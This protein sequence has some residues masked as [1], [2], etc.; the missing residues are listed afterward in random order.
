MRLTYEYAKACH[1]GQRRKNDENYIVH[2]VEVT[3]LLASIPGIDQATLQAA[4]L[5]DVLEDTEATEID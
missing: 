2:P 3:T 5:H 4:L 1:E